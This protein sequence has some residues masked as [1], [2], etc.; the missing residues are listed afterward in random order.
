MAFFDHLREIDPQKLHAFLARRG[1]PDEVRDYIERMPIII[2]DKKRELRV[3][4]RFLV[5]WEKFLWEKPQAYIIKM[6]DLTHCYYVN[7][8]IYVRLCDGIERS[9]RIS[10]PQEGVYAFQEIS[11]Y[12][13]G[14]ENQP[15]QDLQFVV[16]ETK[17][18]RVE[19]NRKQIV[20]IREGGIFTKKITREV[21]ASPTDELIWVINDTVVDSE[22]PD[23]D[24]L[25]LCTLSGKSH[26][27]QCANKKDA[28]DLA[29]KLK[30][31]VPHLLYGPSAEYERL[32][33]TDPSRL[34]AIGKGRNPKSSGIWKA[35]GSIR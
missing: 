21:L 9:F 17:W 18:S 32:F 16:N 10:K 1:D 7:E 3:D 13:R 11:R 27:I 35:P 6:E 31:L 24:Y 22:G 23:D 33:R 5:W 15:A 28:Y 8:V 19:I 26:K 34:L 29:L 14:F 20:R 4:G 12:V 2:C 25:A 30:S